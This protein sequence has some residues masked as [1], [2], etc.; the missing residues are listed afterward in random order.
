MESE[1]VDAVRSQQ[2]VDVPDISLH[3]L[4]DIGHV[5]DGFA[6][7][8]DDEAGTAGVGEVLDAFGGDYLHEFDVSEPLRHIRQVLVDQQAELIAGFVEVQHHEGLGVGLSDFPQVLIPGDLQH[9][10][11]LLLRGLDLDLLHALRHVLPGEVVVEVQVV[12]QLV[13]LL[14]R[15]AIQFV[16]ELVLLLLAGL[17]GELFLGEGGLLLVGQVVAVL[18]LQVEPLSGHSVRHY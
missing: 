4:V 12:L 5:G 8:V 15:H 3:V 11:V 2:N 17:H 10:S 6:G 16:L 13:D 9:L 7:L 18:D 1:G 14:H